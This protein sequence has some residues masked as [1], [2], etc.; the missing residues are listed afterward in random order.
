MKQMLPKKWLILNNKMIP[1]CIKRI[2]LLTSVYRAAI[3]LQIHQL[4]P[5]GIEKSIKLF[6]WLRKTWLLNMKMIIQIYSNLLKMSILLW[7]KH[8]SPMKLLISIKMILIYLLRM[9]F[10]KMAMSCQIQ[11]KSGKPFPILIVVVK[12]FLVFNSSLSSL[13]NKSTIYY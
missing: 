4:R 9:I 1:L 5:P 13:C 2:K 8:C 3:Q 12:K 7:K 11:L 6:R 10:N